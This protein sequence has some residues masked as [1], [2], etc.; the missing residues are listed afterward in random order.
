MTINDNKAIPENLVVGGYI[1]NFKEILLIV[2]IL[3][4]GRI[5]EVRVKNLY[6]ALCKHSL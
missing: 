3:S 4:R 5:N 2:L 1:I 6:L